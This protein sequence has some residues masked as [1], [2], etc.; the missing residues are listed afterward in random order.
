MLRNKTNNIINIS[1]LAIAIACVITIV[2]YVQDELSYDK[3]FANADH[4]FQVNGSGTDN[5]VESTTGGNTAPAVGPT[6]QNMYPEIESYVRIY[7]PGDVLVRYEDNNRAPDFYTEKQVLAVDSNFLQVFNYKI[8]EGNPATCLQKPNSVVITEAT[9]KKYFGSTNP[10]GKILLFDVDKKP[11]IVTAV[12]KNI[13]SNSSF[14]FDMLAP[15][16][17]Y[18]EVKK[19]SWNWFWLQVNTYVR[20]KDNVGVDEASVAKLESKF[21]EMV[22][23]H[24]FNKEYGQSYDEFVK[25]GNRFSFSLMPFA[26]VHLHAIP[27]QVPARLTTLSDIKYIYIFSAIALF[28]IILAC[29]NFM[30]LSTAQSATRAKEVGIRKVMGSVRTQLIK[31]FLTEAML[32]S[33]LSTIIALVLVALLL[34]PFNDVSGKSLVFSSIFTTYTWLFV[35][36]LCLITG[37]LAGLYPAFYLTKFNP[38]EVLK[39]MKLFKNNISNLLIR[40]GLVVFQFTISI[41]LIVCTIIVFQQLKYTQYKDLGLNKEDVVVIAN[42]KRLGNVEETFREELTKQNGVIDASASTGVPTNGKFEDTYN[43]EE[44]ESDKPLIKEMDISSFMVDEDFIP[45]L[46]MQMLQGRNFLKTFN[47]SASVILNET[48]AKQI[49][50]KDPVGKYLAYPGNDQRFKVIGVVKDFNVESLRDLVQPF[51]LF[52]AASKTYYT[53]SSFISVRLQPGN[54]NKYMSGIEDKWKSFAPDIP[55]DYSFM[56]EEFDALYRSEHRMGAVFSVFTYL[57][58]F[59]ACLGLFGLSIFTAERRRKEISVRKV[60]GASVQGIVQ[61]LSKD[62]IKL[63]AIA[64]VFAAPFAWWAMNEW[65]QSFAYRINISW[66]VFALAGLGAVFIAL[67]TVSFQ[68]IKAA[69]ANP[70]KNLKTE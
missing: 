53:K 59:V 60:L 48:A 20:L 47:D 66:W 5:G 64:F 8:L 50:W 19:R 3:F 17:A 68:A 22:K 43:P 39:G 36:G 31:Q 13:P 52:N 55:F 57:S 4:I 10:I 54:I 15:I 14:Q 24:M 29:V 51:A 45:T 9:A 25:K 58:I 70:V 23:E 34:K 11:F 61:M 27:M 16:V 7:R 62:F 2:M 44:A 33:F 28:I 26:T 56:D 49:G 46:K 37:M 1:G 30:N 40:D 32:Y 21:P 67:I 6:L 35:L 63:V 38:V 69:I 18:G 65:L 12:L 41:A 42:T